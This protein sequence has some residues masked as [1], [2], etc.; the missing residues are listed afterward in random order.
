MTD[1]RHPRAA[2]PPSRRGRLR[3]AL[4]VRYVLRRLAGTA[5]LLLV[6]SLAVFALLRL[7]PGD[8]A[9]TLLGTRSAT[10]EAL[11]SVRAAHHLDE[12]LVTQYARWLTDAFSGD[13]GTSIRTGESVAAAL[14]DRL[15]LTGQLV[16]AGFAVALLLGIPLGVLA[17]LRARR[18]VDRAVQSAGVLALSTPAFAGGL[19]L[20]YVFSLMLGWLPAYGPG[21]GGP[22]RLLHLLL[23]GATLGLAVTAVLI[24]LVRAAVVRELARD[25]VTFALAR[26]VPT[27]TVLFRYVLRGTVV[28]VTTGIGLVLAYLLAGTVMVEQVF[29][30]PGLGQLLV[31]SVTFKDVPVVQAEALLIAALVCLA[32]LATD[33]THPL[34]DPRLRTDR[35]R[36]RPGRSTPTALTE[37]QA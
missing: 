24:K 3:A 29:A 35:R 18:P 20:I 28:P 34:A 25:H 12:P 6:L 9:R 10:P 23:P 19:L 21:T 22:D 2:P 14:G 37:G 36:R 31:Q 16:L 26:G 32:N 27:R 15:A 4:P 8:P 11:A 1:P 13:L 5:G 30:L 7:A 17:G 33:L